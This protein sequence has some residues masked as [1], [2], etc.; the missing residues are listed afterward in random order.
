M[1]AEPAALPSLLR[2]VRGR[3]SLAVLC[4]AV[5]ALLGIAPFVAVAELARVLLA[6]GQVDRD[7]AWTVTALAGACLLARLLFLVTASVVSHLAEND[8][9]LSVRRRLV[10]RLDRVPLGWFSGRG[11]GAVKKAVQD[12]VHA[13][14]H[15]VAHS[16]LELTAAVIVP[17]ATL[18]YLFRVDWRLTLIT[19]I[20]LVL[21]IGLFGRTGAAFK[22]NLPALDAA[23]TDVN[24][25]AVEFV[26]GI[27]VVKTFG[28][29]RRAHR[30]Y[31]DAA[32]RFA[33]FFRGWVDSLAAPRA[34]SEIVLS[35]PTMLFTVLLGGT[36]LITA[37]R[38]APADL[39]PFALLAV[40]ITTP[41]LTISFA[42]EEVRAA[43]AAADRIAEVLATPELPLPE[44]PVTAGPGAVTFEA[45]GFSHDG[46]HRVLDGVDLTLAPGTTTALVGPSGAGKSTLA[47]LLPRFW[48]PDEGTI[49]VGGTDLRDLAPEELHR[50]MS[51]V[52]QDVR[53]LR[54][55][56]RA[57]LLIARPDATGEQLVDAA[58]RA[59]IHDRI[60]EL[61]RGYDSVV[62][63]DARF[64]GGE[65]QRLSI[66][67][68]MLADTPVL[69]LDEATAY[70]DPESEA[71]VQ[72]ALSEL[73]RG[74]TL[75]VV[76]HRLSTVK[77]ADLIVVLDGG[78]VVERGTH[79]ELLAL[80]GTYAGMWQAHERGTA[81]RPG[82]PGEPADNDTIRPPV[83]E[84]VR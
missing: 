82:G 80:R 75:L 5:A 57:N 25:A 78:R 37:G 27:A 30:R 51:F 43:K 26:Q 56:V 20:P 32:D 74:R 76:A 41:V 33:A 68:A 61:P 16:L 39:V 49:R 48:D 50:R 28:Q 71:A 65:A 15:L 9:Q 38:T 24:G 19:M 18:A 13:L 17:L 67:R 84:A 53:L 6:D 29:T 63:E 58:R 2:P 1:A 81:R 54:D 64:S 31:A 36:A 77:D 7:R 23:M 60:T 4:Q 70:A 8:L 22:K 47:A 35:A 73:T 34:L 62:G 14:H 66:A 59:R 46:A 3:L 10:G 40:G 42:E 11:G 12:D 69:V 52:F 45:V 44:H 21:G 72:D 55:T 83:E 79:A